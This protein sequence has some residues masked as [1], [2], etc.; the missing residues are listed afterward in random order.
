M[1]IIAG[2][3]R[4]RRLVFPR[5][6]KTRPM[7]DRAK[8]T[9]FNILG[10]TVSGARVLDLFA[11]SGSMGLEAL[12][13]G[14]TEVVFVESGVWAHKTIRQNLE[15]LGL[16]KRASVLTNNFFRSVVAL[17][18]KGGKFSIIFLDPPYN[19]GLARKGL[20]RLDHSGILAPF[21]KIIVHH[22]RQEKLPE[23]LRN[24]ES[25]REKRIGQA[26]LSFLSCTGAK[27][28]KE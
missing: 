20:I 18:K 10:D 5:S 15:A 24:L 3:F 26:C 17:E 1:R 19:Q 12:S 14:A 13:R 23:S 16:E 25:Y 7:T 4:S 6:K 28:A 11:G 27:T 2:E 9:I 22:S 21:A 8:E